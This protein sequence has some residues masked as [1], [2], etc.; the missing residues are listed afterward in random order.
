DVKGRQVDLLA[1]E[2]RKGSITPTMIAGRAAESPDEIVLGKRTLR[3]GGLAIGDP[4]DVALG[5]TATRY[6]IVGRAVFPDFAGAARLGDG[7]ETTLA[8]ARRLQRAAIANV[9]LVRVTPHAG[10]AA[11]VVEFKLTQA[12]HIHLP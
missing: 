5:D 10:G 1:I 6:T 11:L 12:L 3:E 4:V 8:G 7:A 2:P 9:L